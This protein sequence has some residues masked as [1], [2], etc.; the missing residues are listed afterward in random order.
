MK[1]HD[2][3]FLRAAKTGLLR[4]RNESTSSYQSASGTKKQ[5]AYNLTME[6]TQRRLRPSKEL[7][8][9]TNTN[10]SLISGVKRPP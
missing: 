3:P 1:K 6:A 2:F 4:T 7:E 5:K 8:T 9:G 10:T